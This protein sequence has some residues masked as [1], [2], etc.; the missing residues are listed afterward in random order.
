MQTAFII[1]MEGPV[2]PDIAV[3]KAYSAILANMNDDEYVV[4]VKFVSP[5]PLLVPPGATPQNAAEKNVSQ[6]PSVNPWTIGASV[7]SIMG[8]FVS[9]MVYAKSRQSRKRRQQLVEEAA[10]FVNSE[11]EPSAI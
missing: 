3:F 6:S 2:D 4:P 1:G 9:L 7:A 11:D 8:G 10:P 5:L